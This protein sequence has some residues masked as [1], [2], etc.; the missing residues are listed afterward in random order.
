MQRAFVIIS[1]VLLLA[2]FIILLRGNLD[3]AFVVAVIGIV[4]WFLSFRTKLKARVRENE[5]NE[6][7]DLQDDES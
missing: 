4:A 6:S 5:K 7:E 1:A 2:A 3:A